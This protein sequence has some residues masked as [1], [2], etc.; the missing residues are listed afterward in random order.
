M[1]NAISFT[2]WVYLSNRFP[3]IWAAGPQRGTAPSESRVRCGCPTHPCGVK[4]CGTK[5]HCAVSCVLFFS[6]WI[7]QLCVFL[8]EHLCQGLK[9]QK[10]TNGTAMG[11][12]HCFWGYLSLTHTE[13]RLGHDST[14]LMGYQC[15][16]NCLLMPSCV[17]HP[18]CRVQS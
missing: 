15:T 11:L 4:F 5:K 10:S 18:I 13:T 9:G 7:W 6:A 3:Q 16:G 1:V 17:F 8:N 12:V 2:D 14:C